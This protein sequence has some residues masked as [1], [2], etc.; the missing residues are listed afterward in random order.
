MKKVLSLLLVVSI[1]FSFAVCVGQPSAYAATTF[2]CVDGSAFSVGTTKVT[3]L[4]GGFPECTYVQ[5]VIYTIKHS[6]LKDDGDVSFAFVDIFNNSRESV[7]AFEKQINCDAIS[8]C[9]DLTDTALKKFLEYNGGSYLSPTLVY[10]DSKGDVVKYHNGFQSFLEILNDI[11]AVDDTVLPTREKTDASGNPL[12]VN[13]YKKQLENGGINVTSFENSIRTAVSQHKTSLDISSLKIRYSR[14]MSSAISQYIYYYMPD[15]SAIATI[16]YSYSGNYFT[17]VNL[18]YK[19]GYDIDNT[20]AQFHEVSNKLLN[21][22]IHNDNLNDAEKALIVHDRLASYAKYDKGYY[23]DSIDPD[24]YTLYGPFIKRISVCQGFALAYAYLMNQA[25]IDTYYINSSDLNH[26]WNVIMI[27]GVAY[28]VDVTWDNPTFALDGY[29]GHN[30]FLRSKQGLAAT[31][32][33]SNTNTIDYAT[34][35]NGMAINDTKYDNYYWQNSYAEFQLID[36]TLYY[37]DNA[38]GTLNVAD[39]NHTVLFTIPDSWSSYAKESEES[40]QISAIES[41]EIETMEMSAEVE[42]AERQKDEML[43]TNSNEDE[44]VSQISSVA[45]PDNSQAVIPAGEERYNA[46]QVEHP[47]SWNNCSR[48]S[49]LNHLLLFSGSD[50]VYQ[51]NL[52]TKKVTIPFIPDKSTN[53]NVED[54]YSIFGF[55]YEAGYLYCYLYYSV[56]CR[57]GDK[58]DYLIRAPFAPANHQHSY[59]ETIL[60]QP[61]C[62]EK[63]K[64]NYV[65]SVCGDKQLEILP[66]LGHNF[67]DNTCSGCALKEFEY[68]VSEGGAVIT[69]YNGGKTDIRIPETLDSKS[70]TQIGE[71]AFSSNKDIKKVTLP[72]TVTKIDKQAF[73]NCTSLEN[74]HLPQNLLEIGES[75]FRNC[76]IKEIV[77]PNSLIKI[78]NY[79]FY[80]CE[81]LQS[82]FIGSGVNV[83]SSFVFSHCPQLEHMVV[84]EQNAVYDSRNN[85]NAI[86][87]TKTN[88]LVS[89][90]SAS[91]VP[92]GTTA[93]GWGAFYGSSIQ[94][95]T[96]PVSVTKVEK[97]AFEYSNLENVIYLGTQADWDK[98]SIDSENTTLT[99]VNKIYQPCATHVYDNGQVTTEPTC[100]QAGVKTYTCRTCG[101]VKTENIAP[102]GMHIY[103]NGYCKYCDIEDKNYT[104]PTIAMPFN[105]NIS[106]YNGR[107]YYA[108]FVPEKSGV[109]DLY[110]TGERDTVAYLYDDEMNNIAYND[111]AAQN[112]LNFAIKCYV[113]AGKAYTVKASVYRANSS[114][115]FDLHLA[116]ENMAHEHEYRLYYSLEPTCGD[117]GQQAYQCSICGYSYTQTIAPTDKHEFYSFISEDPTCTEKGTRDYYCYYCG[118]SYKEEIPALG[119][120]FAAGKQYCQ[121]GC[122]TENPEYVT[123]HTHA[124]NAVV[125]APKAT[126]LGYTQY[127]CACGVWKKN[128]AGKVVK[129]TFTA[130]TGKLTLKCSARVANAEK[131][132]WNNVK[133]ASGYQVQISNAAGNKWATIATL[134]AGV[135]NYTFKKLA[136]GT[137]Y[138][139]RVRFYIKGGDGKNYFSPWSKTLSSPT[140][141]AGTAFTKLTPAKRAFVAQWKKQAVSGYQVQ[142]SLKANFA[143]AKTITVKN[144]KLL[145][146][147]AAKLY[148]G[149]YYFV[150][151]RT[152]KTIARANYY[153]A[154]SKA[155]KVKTK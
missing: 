140:L 67:V 27:D 95:I 21:G 136:A 59:V 47:Y 116:Y 146:A 72:D 126:A 153:A 102:T 143:G 75:A 49:S 77:L 108:K 38:A 56:T 43:V 71:K 30:N 88:E 64:K 65:C 22:V 100:T 79:A 12:A 152:Y 151:I 111:D 45:H 98:I 123:P 60:K 133:T 39:E 74:L 1:L 154:W 110:S 89:G 122:G 58:E 105:Q 57:D 141:P 4:V 31:G 120:K 42:M 142:Y 106:V 104:I 127:K 24:S 76:A 149:K 7:A 155:Y 44:N 117:A 18:Q 150:R 145:K 9:Y 144:P 125:T 97:Y 32:H 2:T 16:S 99:N 10:L 128:A 91:T 11:H 115:E 132:Q 14:D 83:I 135:T 51:Y 6:G 70:V 94:S 147:T 93:I 17:R 103:A 90:C 130:P 121:N 109:I 33:I 13:N 92:V 85:C 50:W 52:D 23:T 19:S 26:A 69:A 41:D 73:Y 54:Y 113:E 62:T 82:V 138:R 34:T 96:L 5:D 25:G 35:I 131:V 114:G 81:K 112:N 139:F 119:H 3:V 40:A 137:N 118:Y 84:S 68:E 28:Y 20:L 15:V 8:F 86:L 66:A 129:D 46:G 107:E 124:Y 148:A 55:K 101:Y 61:T 78:E 134:K 53:K 36:N 29:V 80:D 87:E 48:L 63:G 37:I